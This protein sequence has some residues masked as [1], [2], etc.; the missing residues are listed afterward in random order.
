MASY[1]N[2][3]PGAIVLPCGK[4]EPAGIEEKTPSPKSKHWIAIELVYEDD[5]EP[6][7]AEEYCV[8]L[9]SGDEIRGYLN[10]H[11]KAHID[12]IDDEGQCKIEFPNLHKDAWKSA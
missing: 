5:G 3:Q 2:Q 6:L 10:V 7:G 4:T 11:G 1:S 9:P 12:Y 8:T